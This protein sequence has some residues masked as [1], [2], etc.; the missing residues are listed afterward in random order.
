MKILHR[1]L[2][3]Q[4][5]L[6]SLAAIVTL[7]LIVLMFDAFKRL[8]V[9]LI[10]NDVSLLTIF[11]M[12]LLLVPQALALTIPCGLLTGVVIVFGRMCHSLEITALR[13]AGLGLIPFIAPIIL[14]SLFLSLFCF[15]NNAVLAPHA[16][17]K[18]KLMFIE[19]AKNNPT[20]FIRAQEPV[21]RFP[22]MRVYVEKKYGNTL[23]GIHIWKLGE[24]DIPTSS[25]RAD[26]GIISTDL[27]DMSLTITLFNARQEDRGKDPTQLQSIQTGMKAAQ[28]PI[29]VSI[30][31]MLDT[32]KISNNISILPIEELRGRLFGSTSKETNLI[33]LLTELQRRLV[34]SLS[35]FTFVLVGIPLAISTGRKETSIGCLLSLAVAVVYFLLVLIAMAFKDNASAYPELIVWIPTILFQGLGF[36]LLKKVNNHPV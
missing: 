19:M 31:D 36:Y 14:L 5:A 8:A 15:Y 33:P 35:C 26:R 27:Q 10:D 32:T 20:A 23:E 25:I 1:H 34:F 30:R 16:M 18:F 22:G 17:T 9:L 28:L 13:A 11:Y 3:K 24:K 12:L 2:L 7:T 4:V 6:T 29:K 21:D